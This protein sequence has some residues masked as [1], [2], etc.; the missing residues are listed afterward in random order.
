MKCPRCNSYVKY[1]KMQCKK[2]GLHFRYSENAEST[3]KRSTASVLARTGGLLG[4]HH[5]Y[6]CFYLRG[7]I[8]L[9]LFIGFCGLFVC[10][11]LAT[12]FKTGMFRVE[13]DAIDICGLIMLIVNII[14]YVLAIIESMRITE[15]IINTDSNGFMLR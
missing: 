3:R 4:L 1:G 14:S 5:I 8:R 13:F 2:C 9:V 7:I 6:L 15:G 11:Q 12:I 10:P